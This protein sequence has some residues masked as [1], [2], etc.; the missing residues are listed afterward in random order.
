MALPTPPAAASP[1]D[2]RAGNEP[3]STA[4]GRERRRRFFL[5]AGP[6]LPPRQERGHLLDRLAQLGDRAES[7]VGVLLQAALDDGVDRPGDL[8]EA[9]R[10]R[11]DDRARRAERVLVVERLD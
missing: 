3:H 8:A 1:G 5:V 11:G 4:R 6:S 9:A 10:D 7:V 2:R